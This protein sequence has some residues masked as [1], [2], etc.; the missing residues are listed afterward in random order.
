LVQLLQ[1]LTQGGAHS[2]AD[3]IRG[4][5]ISEELLRQMIEDLARMGYL[6]AVGEGCG[7]RCGDCPVVG[8]CTVGGRGQVWSLTEKGSRVAQKL[9]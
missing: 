2:Y 3:L 8:M 5:G 1:I 9:R 7:A 4:L 6:K